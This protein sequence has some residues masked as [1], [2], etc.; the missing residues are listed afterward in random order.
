M[1]RLLSHAR[2]NSIG[3]LA[4]FVAL[5]GTSYAAFGVPA[6]SVG[7]RQLRSGAVTTQKLANGSVTPVKLDA[8]II[9]GSVRHWAQVSAQGTIESSS[10]HAQDNGVPPDGDYVIT[11]SDNFSNRCVAIATPQGGLGLLTPLSG[12]ANTHIGGQHPTVVW[13]TTYNAQG[14]SS[15]AAFSLAVIC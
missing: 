6:G 13:V 14:H 11:W 8:H 1:I 4:L 12:I 5:G 2:S 7:T 15:P 3:Y 9:A 10:G